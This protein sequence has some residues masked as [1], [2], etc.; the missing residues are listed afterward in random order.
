[1]AILDLL[2]FNMV[3]A[4]PIVTGGAEIEKSV[5]FIWF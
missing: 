2:D 1:L 3:V 4:S 5:S